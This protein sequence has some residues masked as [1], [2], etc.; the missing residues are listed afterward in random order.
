MPRKCSSFVLLIRASLDTREFVISHFTRFV[1]AE[2]PGV[3]AT[4][5][6]WR[7][8][9]RIPSGTLISTTRRGTQ[10]GK[11]GEAQTFVCCG[12]NSHSRHSKTERSCGPT[13]RHQPDMLKTMVQLHPGSIAEEVRRKERGDRRRVA[14]EGHVELQLLPSFRRSTFYSLLLWSPLATWKGVG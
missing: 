9:V 4:L 1:L 6:R 14:C 7:S 8:G 12:F 11:S 5:S 10:T 13:A 2:Q 3:L